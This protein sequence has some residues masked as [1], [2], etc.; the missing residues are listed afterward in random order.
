MS[1][2]NH[3]ELTMASQSEVP[4]AASIETLENSVK[5]SS[6]YHAMRL[7]PTH[8]RHGM[9]AI[10]AFCREVD[11]IADGDD[12]PATKQANLAEWR[13]QI[14]GV[15]DQTATHPIA[16]ALVEPTMVFNLRR[17][18]YQAVIDGMAMDAEADICAPTMAEL[19]LY[20]DRVA[21][22]V[23]RLSVRIFG[24]TGDDADAVAYS[25]GRALQLA[26]ILRDIAEDAARGRLYLPSDL[27]DAHGITT[28]D[29]NAVIRHPNLTAVGVDLAKIA[30]RHF[31]DAE[32]AMARCPRKPM[33]TARLMGAAYR[34]ILD[35]VME[36]GFKDLQ[37]PVKIGKL[38]KLWIVARHGLL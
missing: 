2:S 20:C 1:G 11:D 15:F 25:L 29:L 19:D 16:L 7:M 3:A 23:G 38:T 13:R 34:A 37:A 5:G 30:Y 33:R 14:D 18:D 17:Q 10:Y 24:A 21:S 31:A 22:A 35:K 26:N 6:F 12:P 28:R 8:R 27:L 4:K 36:R 9:F 32:A